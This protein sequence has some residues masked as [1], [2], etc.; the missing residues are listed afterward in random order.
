[1]RTEHEIGGASDSFVDSAA[2]AV[3]TDRSIIVL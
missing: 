2:A 1:M 3:V